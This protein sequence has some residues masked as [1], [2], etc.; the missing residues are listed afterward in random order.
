MPT[1][2]YAFSGQS[3]L[4]Y[5]GGGQFA[6]PLSRVNLT[7][8]I[9]EH[10]RIMAHEKG[11]LMTRLTLAATIAIASFFAGFP[12][13]A[14]VRP[15]PVM[16]P[17]VSSFTYA[18]VAD[19]AT[20]APLV[21]DARIRRA[22]VLPPERA[23]GIAPTMARFYVE[24]DVI[25][26]IRGSGPLAARI[27]WLVDLP[28]DA[29]GKPVKLNKQRVLIFARPVS[30]GQVALVAPDAQLP[31]DA[32]TEALAR[33]IITEVVKPGAPAAVTGIAN[34]FHQPG[35]LPGEGESQF[36]VETKSGEPLTLSVLTAPGQPRRW[37]AAFGEI[38]D[39]SAAVPARDTLGWYRLAC[40]LPRSLPAGVLVGSG[41]AEQRA[42]TAD[43]RFILEQLGEC[44]RTR[45]G[46]VTVR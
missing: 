24:A 18:D 33:R 8:T 3:P 16:P 46:T 22:T 19:L 35:T 10:C 12:A 25:A 1:S 34:G 2:Y 13:I 21:V 20:I 11:W 36:F 4:S 39:G 29:R 5:R 41:S 15:A 6:N 43:Y 7:R 31:W 38:V 40:G 23:P 26:L 42:G 14:Q 37:S 32:P 27:A 9:I 17:V 45:K 28:R 30:T 44:R